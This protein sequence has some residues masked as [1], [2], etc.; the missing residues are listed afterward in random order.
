MLELQ[1]GTGHARPGRA[2]DAA[3]Q[4]KLTLIEGGA[5]T[6]CA[7]R[8]STRRN[9]GHFVALCKNTKKNLKPTWQL[10]SS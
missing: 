6:R 3:H 4:W 1:Y 10:R 2:A 7:E 5:T 9:R 8:G